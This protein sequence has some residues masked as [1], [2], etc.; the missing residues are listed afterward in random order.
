MR[1]AIIWTALIAAAAAAGLYP[2]A[3]DWFTVRAQSSDVVRHVA[4]VR[5]LTPE[6]S[7]RMLE[8]ADAHN[9]ALAAGRGPEEPYNDGYRAQLRPP[10]SPIMA[11]ISVPSI[12]LAIPVYHGTSDD[13]LNRGA[14]H[15]PSTSLPVGGPSTH[16][17]VTAHSGLPTASLFNDLTAVEIGDLIKVSVPG[18]TLHYRVRDLIV[19][20]PGDYGPYLAIS[21]GEDLLT[22]FT[23]TPYAINTHRLLVTAERIDNPVG[24]TEG[25]DFVSAD[26]GFPW[27]AAIFVTAVGAGGASGRFI[28]SSTPKSDSA[29]PETLKREEE[30][31]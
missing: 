16:A 17:V 4:A 26:A 25:I 15:H 9:R 2:Q 22:L 11:Q 19:V 21:P 3:A 28:F 31:E 24:A 23:C 12:D 8:A 20:L 5:E 27:W 7:I 6:D 30:T 10:G 14:G 1:K 13:V 18:R 29:K